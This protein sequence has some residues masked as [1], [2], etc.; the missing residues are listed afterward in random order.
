MGGLYAAGYTA[1]GAFGWA[2]PSGGG[3]LGNAFVIGFLAG[4][5]VAAQPSRNIGG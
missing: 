3:T 2:D 4:R 5:H 1:A